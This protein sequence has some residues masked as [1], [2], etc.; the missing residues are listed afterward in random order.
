MALDAD[1]IAIHESLIHHGLNRRQNALERTLAGMAEGVHNI[2][3]QHQVAIAHV[4]SN[5]DGRPRSRPHETIHVLR[6]PLVK[7]DH[8][9]ILLRWIE[10]VGL[11]ECGL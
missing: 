1:R 4:I 10:I 11:V 8:H 5:V 3:S 7:I 6:K 2:G 9:R